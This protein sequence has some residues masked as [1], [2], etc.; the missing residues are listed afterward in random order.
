MRWTGFGER[1]KRGGRDRKWAGTEEHF[2]GLC[3]LW[4][5]VGCWLGG[6]RVDGGLMVD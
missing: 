4:L 3:E 1:E 6:G 5:V 2:G